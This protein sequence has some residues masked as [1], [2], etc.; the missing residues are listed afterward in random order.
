MY[1]RSTNSLPSW[2]KNNEPS[3]QGKYHGRASAG[4]YSWAAR[5]L[6]RV[7]GR[8]VPRLAINVRAGSTWIPHKQSRGPG[9]RAAR[10]PIRQKSRYRAT[11]IWMRNFL[12]WTTSTRRRFGDI[13]VTALPPTRRGPGSYQYRVK[14]KRRGPAVKHPPG[15][16]LQTVQVALVLPLDVDQSLCTGPVQHRGG[17]VGGE[18]LHLAPK[19]P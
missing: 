19:R 6:R 16:F 10:G 12:D 13:L 9:R 8:T 14:L 18:R 4:L 1:W 2:I 15:F 3:Q 17:V 5:R 11:D 7:C